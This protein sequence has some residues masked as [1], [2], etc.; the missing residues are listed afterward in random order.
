MPYLLGRERYR[1]RRRYRSSGVL[2]RADDK[3]R[4]TTTQIATLP[5]RGSY[6]PPLRPSSSPRPVA[7]FAGL[8][9]AWRK[10]LSGD[11]R[12]N[13][14]ARSLEALSGQHGDTPGKT[15][16]SHSDHNLVLRTTARFLHTNTV[17]PES[18]FTIASSIIFR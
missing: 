1:A 6:V 14:L 4:G 11:V 18:F 17:S 12:R 13:S 2:C 16:V 8:R 10:C 5:G 7:G 9:Q 3:A 15:G